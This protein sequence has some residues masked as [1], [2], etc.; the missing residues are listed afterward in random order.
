V[1]TKFGLRDLVEK[2]DLVGIR[3]WFQAQVFELLSVIII[4]VVHFVARFSFTQQPCL[5]FFIPIWLPGQGSYL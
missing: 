5:P 4:I 3:S 1:L 2:R